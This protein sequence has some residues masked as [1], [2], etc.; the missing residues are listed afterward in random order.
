MFGN[1]A[2]IWQNYNNM[3]ES[4]ENIFEKIGNY[5]TIDSNLLERLNSLKINYV[6]PEISEKQLDFAYDHYK[7][8]KKL[9][10]DVD[11]K[12]YHIYKI[13]IEK[14]F[15]KNDL[16]EKEDG[17]KTLVSQSES[18]IDHM[19]KCPNPI[20]PGLETAYEEGVETLYNAILS[21]QIYDRDDILR[22]L[23]AK[24]K[25]NRI[26]KSL[27][28]Y[29]GEDLANANINPQV[30]NINTGSGYDF[31]NRKIIEQL[32]DVK[33]SKEKEEF[34]TRKSEKLADLKK[35]IFDFNQE[36]GITVKRTK[37]IK[38]DNR[39]IRIEK[40]FNYAKLASYIVV[41]V[42]AI[43]GGYH[44]G[45]HL[46]NKIDE[47]RTVTR[48]VNP[49]TKE[50][51]D[52]LSDTYQERDITYASTLKVYEAWK[53]GR[54]GYTRKVTA[55]VND[56]EATE[57]DNLVKKYNYT[58]SKEKLDENDNTDES[59]TLI[60]ETVQDKN[61]SRK[62][63]KYV[64]WLAIAGGVLAALI[65]GLL[66][67]NMGFDDIINELD[68]LSKDLRDNKIDMCCLKDLDKIVKKNRKILVD[69]RN[70]ANDIYQFSKD[71]FSTLTITKKTL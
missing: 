27:S 1:D 65:D 50:T 19:L 17:I 4:I 36:A 32:V 53:P 21:E 71:E 37:K 23:L 8:L 6:G 40:G 63:R 64:V 15:I 41:P 48:V 49:V 56:P 14:D 22:T 45:V 51:V 5:T 60:T 7:E 57:T 62:S 25:E 18:I 39:G 54:G 46:S 61:D 3:V 59:I 52:V 30:T 66:I 55:Y 12:Y 29:L 67:Y 26:K 43:T 47:Y 70:G 24:D 38:K 2:K 34:Y 28:I 35:R 42:L 44:L 9:K 58:E 16:V 20:D 31:I 11:A 10:N 33:Y 69:E 68:R 13:I